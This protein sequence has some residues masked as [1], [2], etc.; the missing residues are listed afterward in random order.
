DLE[1]A[2][3][4][5]IPLQTATALCAVL[6]RTSPRIYKDQLVAVRGLLEEHRE[7]EGDLETAITDLQ[8]NSH[9]FT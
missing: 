8:D 6:K 9:I 3:G 7:V 5:L 4:T 2:I 1:H